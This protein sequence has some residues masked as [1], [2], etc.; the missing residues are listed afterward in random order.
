MVFDPSL[1]RF[2]DDKGY[3]VVERLLDVDDLCAVARRVEEIVADP[4]R[5]PAG[6]EVGRESDT[7]ADKTAPRSETDSL[8]KLGCMA[9]YDPAFQKLAT[10]P[11][12]LSVVRGLIGPRV[13]LFRDQVLLKPPG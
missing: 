11:R 7:R 1:K 10:H 2:Y 8:R 13:K 6:V 9:R 12:L 5:A 4:S 3:L